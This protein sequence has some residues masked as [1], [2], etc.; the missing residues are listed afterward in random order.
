METIEITESFPEIVDE[1]KLYSE[2]VLI[3]PKEFKL[4]NKEYDATEHNLRMKQPENSFIQETE[5]N[6]K[7]NNVDL[8]SKLQQLAKDRNSM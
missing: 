1:E 4:K 5:D 6:L 8:F 3:V 2:N 7:I